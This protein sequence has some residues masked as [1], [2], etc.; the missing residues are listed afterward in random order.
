MAQEA[1][2][3]AKKIKAE[4][5]A[6]QWSGIPVEQLLNNFFSKQLNCIQFLQQIAPIHATKDHLPKDIIT[7]LERLGKVDNMPF[8]KLYYLVEN[9]ADRYFTSISKTFIEIIKWS[10]TDRQIMLV[11]TARA[12]KYLEDFGQRQS[13]LLTVLQKYHLFLDSLEN[14]QSQFGFLKQATSKNV[15]HLQ[16]AITVQQTYTA[17]LCTF[18]NNILPHIKKLEETILQ[19]E[20][21]FTT[22]QDTIQINVLDFDLDIDGPNHPRTHNNT[23]IVSVQE[24]LT[25]PE[26]EISD[27]ANFQEEDTDIDPPDTTYNNSK[28]SHGY[29]N[30]PQDI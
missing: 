6:L 2:K 22:E 13:Q 27:A 25:S 21:K 5:K 26:L 3:L 9:C 14:L 19:L 16:Q 8:D 23:A 17:N 28:E 15:E 29:D 10:T 7:I 24:H 4:E 30:F 20:Q 11:N 1:K 12:L 18:I